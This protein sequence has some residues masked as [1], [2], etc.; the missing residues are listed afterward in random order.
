MIDEQKLAKLRELAAPRGFLT[1]DDVRQAL[2]V[3]R[4]S[5]DEIAMLMLRLEEAGIAV[6]LDADLA[7]APRR[8]KPTAP[9]TPIIDLPAGQ[10]IAHDK[11][12]PAP[13]PG[14]TPDAFAPPEPVAQAPPAAWREW[15]FVAAAGALIALGAL[16][17]FF[18]S[19]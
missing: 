15:K 19:R 16:V 14:L 2:P 13:A 6:E 8:R 10:P 7:G 4:M 17:L 12:Q 18:L 11:N 5:A 3:E 9:E 1:T